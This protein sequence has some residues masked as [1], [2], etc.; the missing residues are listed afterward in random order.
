M[1]S[2]A[3]VARLVVA[4]SVLPLLF[5][6]GR[7]VRFVPSVFP[8]FAT[9]IGAIYASYVFTLLESLVAEAPMNAIQHLL[10]GAAGIAA[11]GMAWFIRADVMAR[12]G[13]A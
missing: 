3:E 9:V 1:D 10:L 13:D 5:Y 8:W 2:A 12:K 4:V 11:V 6:A 7:H